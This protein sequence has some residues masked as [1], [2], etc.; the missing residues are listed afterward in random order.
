MKLFSLRLKH[1]NNF[2]NIACMW[3]S[4]Y[5]INVVVQRIIHFERQGKPMEMKTFSFHQSRFSC[6]VF[7]S[8]I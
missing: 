7:V 4:I 1:I 6:C 2:L 3:L 5:N 8:L